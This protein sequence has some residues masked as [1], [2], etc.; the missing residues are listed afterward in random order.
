MSKP[1]I[2][3]IEDDPVQA[4]VL[5]HSLAPFFKVVQAKNHSMVPA[6]FDALVS[7]WTVPHS[8]V[9]FRDGLIRR[10]IKQGIPVCIHTAGLLDSEAEFRDVPIITKDGMGNSLIE[11]LRRVLPLPASKKR[12]FPAQTLVG[13]LSGVVGFN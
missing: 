13:W 2:V 4:T 11:W 1:V 6:Q 5:S 7:D 9:D 3:L 12:R 8:W 10:A